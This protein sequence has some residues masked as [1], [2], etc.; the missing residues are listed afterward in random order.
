MTHRTDFSEATP[1]EIAAEVSEALRRHR[2]TAVMSGGG[3][4]S[5]Y[6]ENKYHSDDLDFIDSYRDRPGIQRALAEI[7]FYSE[8]TAISRTTV[9]MFTLNS[10]PGR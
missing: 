6:S 5:V 2:I 9:P 7:G 3:C 8:K 1:E 10:S 4:V